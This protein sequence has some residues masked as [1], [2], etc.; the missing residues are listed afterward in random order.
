MVLRLIHVLFSSA[1]L[2]VSGGLAR[3]K[4]GE[5]EE[6]GGGETWRSAKLHRQ[7][8]AQAT[9]LAS[10]RAAQ[11]PMR[12]WKVIGFVG[13]FESVLNG[14]LHPVWSWKLISKEVF[15]TDRGDF[16]VEL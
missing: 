13:L 11:I 4:R 8:I 10:Q 5:A 15:R 12:S 6:E 1:L 7:A 2:L 9:M 16:A 14:S 3:S